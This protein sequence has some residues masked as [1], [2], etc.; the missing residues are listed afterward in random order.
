MMQSKHKT[1]N[2]RDVQDDLWIAGK[3]FTS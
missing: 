3:K 1:T 2:P